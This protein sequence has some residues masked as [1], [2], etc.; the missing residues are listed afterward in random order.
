MK[1]LLVGRNKKRA[2]K[3]GSKGRPRATICQGLWGLM[4]QVRQ[5]QGL[6]KAG[7][8]LETQ[9]LPAQKGGVPLT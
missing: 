6:D 4:G 8:K 7:D 9:P 1:G 5:S 3:M 2:E